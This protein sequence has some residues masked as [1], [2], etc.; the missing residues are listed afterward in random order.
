[1]ANGALGAE[2]KTMAVKL[3]KR[4]FEHVESLILSE[5][6]L[7]DGRDP[8]NEHQPSAQKE[9]EDIR[10]HDYS[11]YARCHLGIDDEHGE[12]T[13]GRYKFP[14]GDFEQVHRCGLLAAESRAGQRNY[15]DI[16]LAVARLHGMPEALSKQRESTSK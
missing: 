1:M 15:Y 5:M 6:Y 4:A 7:I 3:H 11:E 14:Y 10:Q 8:G 16:E 9:N 12:G 13:T 2:G